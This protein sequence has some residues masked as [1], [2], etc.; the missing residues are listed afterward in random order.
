[1]LRLYI[2]L[3]VVLLVLEIT[4]GLV[5]SDIAK[6][7]SNSLSGDMMRSLSGT[8][9]EN[10]E[11]KDV[12]ELAEETNRDYE[13]IFMLTH[14]GFFSF[15]NLIVLL[16]TIGLILYLGLSSLVVLTILM[17]F[18]VLFFRHL[19]ITQREVAVLKN[20]AHN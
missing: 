15:S 4:W 18:N 7:I 5:E 3:S 12:Y 20:S 13:E 11:G 16:N 10:I 6:T 8:P 9:I 1:M 17:I 2:I 14:R 19:L